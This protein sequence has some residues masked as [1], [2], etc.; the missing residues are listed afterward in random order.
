MRGYSTL[1]TVIVDC[2]VLHYMHIWH[3][4][5]RASSLQFRSSKINMKGSYRCLK[6]KVAKSRTWKYLNSNKGAWKPLKIT[7]SFEQAY[8]HEIS[9]K[10][11]LTVIFDLQDVE[12]M[13]TTS[14]TYGNIN[15][16]SHITMCYLWKI[17]LFLAIKRCFPEFYRSNQK[18]ALM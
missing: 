1:W 11:M 10:C 15:R 13:S 8:S 18:Y 17:M 7:F 16:P 6:T 12:S 2:I 9:N 5:I 4:R 3:L 14:V